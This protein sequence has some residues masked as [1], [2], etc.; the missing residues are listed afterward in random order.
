[1]KRRE[2]SFLSLEEVSINGEADYIVKKAQV[3]DSRVVALGGL[4][5][6]STQTG[7]AWLLDPVDN[8]ALCLARDGERQNFGILETPT[9]FQISW[10]AQYN[11]EGER[12]TVST[13]DGRVKTILGYPTRE[14]ENNIEKYNLK[15]A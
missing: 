3:H 5:F 12:F 11:I 10:E 7:D 6:F 13:K 1:M 14:I 4:V 2:Q 15:K 8:L 9:N